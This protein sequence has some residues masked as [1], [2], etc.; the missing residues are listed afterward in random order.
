[1][2]EVTVTPQ[3]YYEVLVHSDR[4]YPEV[5]TVYQCKTF[6]VAVFKAWRLS[7][8]RNDGWSENMAVT[9]FDVRKYQTVCGFKTYAV[10]K[11]VTKFSRLNDM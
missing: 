4:G 9:V 8:N 6:L 7:K 1:M 10:P 3:A 5:D 2:F 11:Y